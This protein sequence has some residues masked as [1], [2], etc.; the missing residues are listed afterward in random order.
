MDSYRMV[1][2]SDGG[3]SDSTSISRD[4]R[5]FLCNKCGTSDLSSS[6][7]E[8]YL[9]SVSGSS[10]TRSRTPS[11]VGS[12]RDAYYDE[13]SADQVLLVSP[14]CPGAVRSELVRAKPGLS[15]H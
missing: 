7:P 8:I 4:R 9:S 12:S 11:Q 13:S 2:G 1:T 5:H 6:K 14:L 15:K 10:F 3:S